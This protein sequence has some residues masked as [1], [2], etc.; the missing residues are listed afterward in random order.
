MEERKRK[1][2]NR[3]RNSRSFMVEFKADCEKVLQEDLNETAIR[4]DCKCIQNFQR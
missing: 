2:R 1:A 3:K 4:T